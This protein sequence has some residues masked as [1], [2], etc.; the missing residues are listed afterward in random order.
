MSSATI[1]RDPETMYLF[2]F[3]L[4]VTKDRDIET[5]QRNDYTKHM[6]LK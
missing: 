3:C 2:W 1:Q 6:S 4:L 5:M